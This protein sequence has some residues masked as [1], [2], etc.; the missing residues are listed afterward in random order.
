M[1]S[2]RVLL[3]LTRR[4]TEPHRYYHGIEHIAFMLHLGRDLPLTEEQKTTIRGGGKYNRSERP[5]PVS[6]YYTDELVDA[7]PGEFEKIKMEEVSMLVDT[8][9]DRMDSVRTLF[10]D[11]ALGDSSRRPLS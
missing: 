1:P 9:Q 2:H 7:Y 10:P 3:E 11:L 6:A 5:L 4:Y 8:Q